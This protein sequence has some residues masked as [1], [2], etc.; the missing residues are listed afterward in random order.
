MVY[1]GN[2]QLLPLPINKG[3]NC[4]ILNTITLREAT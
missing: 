1:K 3:N 2:L 4:V